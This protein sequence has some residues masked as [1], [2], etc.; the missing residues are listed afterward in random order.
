MRKV[1]LTGA[2]G[3]IGRR[4][5][6]ALDSTRFGEV[7]CLMRAAAPPGAPL[8]GHARAVPGSL[9][10]PAPWRSAM[11][12][13]DAVIHTAALT[14]RGRAE[15]FER[16][17]VG[18]TRAV[19]EAARAGGAGRLVF[20]SSIAAAYP[21]RRVYPYAQSKDAAEALVR[22]S[23]LRASIVRPTIVFGAGSAAWGPLKGLATLPVIPLFGDGAVRTQPV[24]V[25]DVA[26]GI[27]DLALADPLP[28]GPIAFGGPESLSFEELIQRI[29]RVARPNDGPSP[30]RVVHIPV[31]PLLGPLFALE[32]VV[33]PRL[34]VTAGQLMSFV[35]D[36]DAP[37]H[38]FWSARQGSL[39]T[40]DQ[41]LAGSAGGGR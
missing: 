6:A 20:V 10:D 1:F 36:S 38:P 13:C 14:G 9:E 7:L 19:I 31:K 26:R 24:D 11:A 28:P 3:F 39:R 41:M 34:P 37:P 30:G 32:S 25:A 27:A 33:G 29:R 15:D 35:C 12:G 5:L 18:G 22:S 4:V 40:L 23:G 21:N 16:I 2:S 8:P 17:N